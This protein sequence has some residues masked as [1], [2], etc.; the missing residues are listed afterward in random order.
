MV[1]AARV[2]SRGSGG[3]GPRRAGIRGAATACPCVT[4]PRASVGAGHHRRATHIVAAHRHDAVGLSTADGWLHAS[5]ARVH[6]L[7]TTNG[8]RK[9]FAH[10]VKSD[11]GARILLLE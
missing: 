1:T 3:A 7:R 10:D 11:P 9:S 4:L 5:S 8:L 6:E 2:T